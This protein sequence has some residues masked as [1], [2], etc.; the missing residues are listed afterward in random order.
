MIL[1]QWAP[2]SCWWLLTSSVWPLL[3][4]IAGRSDWLWLPWAPRQHQGWG[5]DLWACRTGIS[6]TCSGSFCKRKLMWASHYHVPAWSCYY[7]HCNAFCVFGTTAPV[8]WRLMASEHL[9]PL[10]PK[11]VLGAHRTAHPVT[12]TPTA[13]SRSTNPSQTSRRCRWRTLNRFVFKN[14]QRQ[15]VDDDRVQLVKK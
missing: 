10:A 9:I 11:D 1:R 12:S 7:T 14:D 2:H 8:A 13:V 3:L 6:G 4:N 5:L 15:R